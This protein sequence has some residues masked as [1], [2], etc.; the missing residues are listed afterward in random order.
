[1]SRLHPLLRAGSIAISLYLLWFFGYEQSLALD[2]RLDAVLMHN[3][4][5]AGAAVLR[6][7][8]YQAMVPDAQSN[9]LFL[10]G[11]PAVVVSAPCD[12]LVLYA[13]FTGFVLAFPGPI[14]HKLWFIPLGNV[15]IYAI[16]VLR[17]AALGINQYYAHESVDFNHHYTFTFVIY[18][19][20]FALW[21]WWATRLAARKPAPTQSETAYAYA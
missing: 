14:R 7:V 21:M 17:I 13:L 18:A 4:A 11:V 8:G 9:V 12:G 5:A 2:G 16:N 20:I 15:L 3:L 6:V 10:N 1:M 19:F